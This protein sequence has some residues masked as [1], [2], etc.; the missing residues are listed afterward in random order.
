MQMLNRS[1]RA[2]QPV[3]GYG[4]GVNQVILNLAQLWIVCGFA[5]FAYAFTSS[6]QY[7]YASSSQQIFKKFSTVFIMDGVLITDTFLDICW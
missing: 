2:F 5:S 6:L 3:W 7:A 4:D 1:T